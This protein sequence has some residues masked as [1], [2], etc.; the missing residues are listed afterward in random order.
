MLVDTSTT[1]L[2]KSLFH[3]IGEIKLKP[4]QL[5]MNSFMIR[6]KN[7]LFINRIVKDFGNL[8]NESMYNEKLLDI[9]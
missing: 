3:M 6:W 2:L 5:I 7:F 8:I 9:N 4:F 1:M